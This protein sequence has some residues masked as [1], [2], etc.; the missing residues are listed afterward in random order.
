MQKSE[1]EKV[2]MIYLLDKVRILLCFVFLLGEGI[3]DLRKKNILLPPVGVFFLAGI[4]IGII[5]GRED[6]VSALAGCSLGGIV[7]L[8]ALFTKEKV[9]FGD[10]FVLLATGALLGIRMNLLML[11]FGLFIASLK[12]IWMLI[13]RRGNRNTKMAFV[14]FLIPGLTLSLALVL[15]SG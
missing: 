11:L 2:K 3:S 13:S 14:P 4:I 7:I 12:G 5:Q 9:G 8:L 6:F 10:G 15:S 1:R